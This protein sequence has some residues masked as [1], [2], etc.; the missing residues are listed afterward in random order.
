MHGADVLADGNRLTSTGVLNNGLD[1]ESQAL[2]LNEGGTV[3]P[4]IESGFDNKPVERVRPEVPVLDGSK[5]VY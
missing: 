3:Q 2:A 4:V 1:Y 5:D